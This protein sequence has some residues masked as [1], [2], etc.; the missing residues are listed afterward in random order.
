MQAKSVRTDTSG[1]TQMYTR[2]TVPEVEVEAAEA[3]HKLLDRVPTH[4]QPQF[5]DFVLEGKLTDSLREALKDANSGTRAAAD[6]ALELLARSL[7]DVGGALEDSG[8]KG[9]R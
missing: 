2:D 6:E 8:D 1:V 3:V 9:D 7:N 4:L 5:L